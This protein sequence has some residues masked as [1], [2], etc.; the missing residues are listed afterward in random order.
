VGVEM[1]VHYAATEISG[2]EFWLPSHA[3]IVGQFNKT[4]TKAEL[5][6]SR[7]RRYEARS[8]IVFEPQ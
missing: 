7:Y 6:F 8:S 3:V 1:D 5:T 2:Q 4:L